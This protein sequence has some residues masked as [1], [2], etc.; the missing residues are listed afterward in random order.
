MITLS[1]SGNSYDI[2]VVVMT[3]TV[4]DPVGVVEAEGEVVV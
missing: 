3:G 1:L 4:V 2:A